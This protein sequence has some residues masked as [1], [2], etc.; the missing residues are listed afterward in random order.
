MRAFTSAYPRDLLGNACATRLHDRV[1]QGRDP[2]EY[3]ADVPENFELVVLCAQELQHDCRIF[4]VPC[5]RVPLD[6]DPND[7]RFW[8][9]WQRAV[10]GASEALDRLGRGRA[11]VCCHMG[12]NRSALVASLMLY[13]MVRAPGRE[14]VAHVR[15]RRRGAFGNPLFRAAVEQLPVRAK[16]RTA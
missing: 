6:D 15:R 4:G 7:P 10:R 3:A 14:I 12:L 1:W 16:R 5:V 13:G 11:L 9:T 2:A 8:L